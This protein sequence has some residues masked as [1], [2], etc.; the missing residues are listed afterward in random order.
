MEPCIELSFTE[1]ELNL[2]LT[3]LQ[4]LPY[5]VSA[6]LIQHIMNQVRAAQKPPQ[7]LPMEGNDD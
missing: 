4:E 2:V 1:K 3:G 5:R 7:E 6:E